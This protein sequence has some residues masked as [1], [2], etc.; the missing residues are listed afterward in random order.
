MI[1]TRVRT[2]ILQAA[3]SQPFAYS[4]A[5]YDTRTA[6]VVEIET[7]DGLVGWGECY[8]PAA[9]TS[10][11]VNSMAPLL[12]G[13][14]PLRTDFLWQSIYARLRDH[15][16]KGVVIQGLSG[17]DIALWDIKGK[18]FGV[19][20]HRLLGGPLRTEV[21]AYATGSTGASQATRCAI[22][23]TKPPGT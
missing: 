7:D 3:L 1:I 13:E 14:D 15:G 23:P 2:H 6:M 4:R 19:P 21:R 20:V 10:A 17:I 8:G 12:I 16:Q 5:W 11:A 18:H 22:S 9:I